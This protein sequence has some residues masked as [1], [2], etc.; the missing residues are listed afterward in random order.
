MRLTGSASSSVMSL[1]SLHCVGFPVASGG[2]QYPHPEVTFDFGAPYTPFAVP[3]NT[4][5]GP[6]V[7]PDTESVLSAIILTA[8]PGRMS[9]TVVGSFRRLPWSRP[10]C[11][12]AM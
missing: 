4:N 9:G 10:P 6:I 7:I 5:R 3:Q 2:S 1:H 11:E 8:P 12:F